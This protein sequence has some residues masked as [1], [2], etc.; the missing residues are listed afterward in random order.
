MAG[1]ADKR[2]VFLFSDTQI[3]EES[4]VE[5]I[6]NLLNTYEV[7]NLMQSGDLV[8]IFENIRPRAK[9]AGMDGSRDALYNFFV[10][11]VSP[12][13]PASH[14]PADRFLPYVKAS[15]CHTLAFVCVCQQVL[16]T[17][18]SAPLSPVPTPPGQAQPARGA[19]L[20]PSGRYLPRA[21]AQVP[22]AGQLHHHRLVSPTALPLSTPPR[23]RY[24]TPP[25]QTIP[26]LPCTTP[27]EILAPLPT[28]PY[29]LL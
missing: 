8:G 28:F 1:E 20:Q 5:D 13:G 19:V 4:F 22:L 9:V 12:C 21:P 10:Q 6:S 14:A 11:E 7:P 17:L 27:S 3:K 29:L 23:P 18:H 2:V 26:L 16:K 25:T 24:C 15:A